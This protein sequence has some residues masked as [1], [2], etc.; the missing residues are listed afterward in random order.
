MSHPSFLLLAHLRTQFGT[1]IAGNGSNYANAYFEIPAI[2]TY[3]VDPAANASVGAT[4]QTTGPASG[5]PSAGADSSQTGAPSSARRLRA[6]GGV[7]PL[8]GLVTLLCALIVVS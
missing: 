8:L 1:N 6:A 5:S 4:P 3:S 2:R 7:G